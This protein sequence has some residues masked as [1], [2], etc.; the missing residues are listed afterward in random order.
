VIHWPSYNQSLVRR[1]EILFSYDFLDSW[2]SELERMNKNKEGKPYIYPDSFILAIGCIRYYFHLPYRQTE[3]I[4]KVAGRRS[5]PNHPCYEQICK[6]INKLNI[7]D[8]DGKINESEDVTIAI[9]STGIKV[10]NRGQWLRDKWFVK[11]K[12]YLKIHVAVNVKTKEIL[13]LEVTD[14]KV[15]DGKMMCRLV[16]CM[17]KQNNAVNIKTV[18]E[19]GAYDSNENFKYLQEKKIQ[20]GIKVRKNSIIS[21]KNNKVRNREVEL[22]T[23]DPLKWKKKRGYGKRWMAETAFSSIKRTYGEYVSATRFQNMVKEMIMKVYLYNL[24]RRMA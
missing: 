11:K 8:S 6:R 10:T 22:Q 12:G 16:D 7:Y 9:D 14:E 1:G 24:F 20:P 21:S 3:G 19:D 23:D 15:H 4:I 18:L 17:L 13:A 5:L 2:D